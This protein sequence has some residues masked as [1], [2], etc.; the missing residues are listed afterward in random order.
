MEDLE[1]E[2]EQLESKL[3]MLQMQDHWDSSDYRYSSELNSQ[4]RKIKEKINGR[5]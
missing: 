1:K 3:F 2:L 4:I 5:I